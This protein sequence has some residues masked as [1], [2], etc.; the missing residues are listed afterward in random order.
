MKFLSI[1]CPGNVCPSSDCPGNVCKAKYLQFSASSWGASL[2]RY[3][4]G[5]RV[6]VSPNIYVPLDRGMSVLQLCRW[7]FSL[8]ETLQQTSFNWSW[9]LFQ[10]TANWG[11]RSPH[12][13]ALGTIHDLRWWLVGKHVGDLLFVI[14][15]LFSLARTVETLQAEICRRERFLKG[16]S[17][18]DRP[19]YVEGDVAH[20]TLRGFHAMYCLCVW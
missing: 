11:F 5:W 13:G 20:P 9:L 6:S 2:W 19:F 7:K 18:I 14:I 3:I 10:K 4:W 8:K 17:Q 16:L 15:E 12:L 1:T